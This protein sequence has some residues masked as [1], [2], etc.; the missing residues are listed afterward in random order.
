[1][2]RPFA[3]RSSPTV[4]A[5]LLLLTALAVIAPGCRSSGTT[6][7]QQP[8]RYVAA[9]RPSGNALARVTQSLDGLAWTVPQTIVDSSGSAVPASTSIGIAWD[10][11]LYHAAWFDGSRLRYATSGN[12]DDWLASASDLGTFP[13][14]S[15]ARPA[16]AAGAG[17]VLVAFLSGSQI[18]VVDI[19][20]PSPL[21]VSGSASAGPALAFGNGRF[22]LAFP[23]AAPRSLQVRTSGDGVTWATGANLPAAGFQPGAVALGFD[24]GRFQLVQRISVSTG[25]LSRTDLQTFTSSDGASWTAADV[26]RGQAFGTGTAIAG[27]AGGRLLLDAST[28]VH[29]YV[30]TSPPVAVGWTALNGLGLTRGRGRAMASFSLDSV[31]VT[32]AQERS[33]DEPYFLVYSFHSRVARPGSTRVH[34]SGALEKVGDDLGDGDMR[35]IPPAM[36]S[37]AWTIE[38]ARDLVDNTNG[39]VDIMGAVIVAIEEDG[40]PD[41][42]VAARAR[43]A[44]TVIAGAIESLIAGGTLG[45]LLNQ[46]SR[47]AAVAAATTSVRNSLGGGSGFKSFFGCATDRDDQIQDRIVLFVGTE[48]FTED[49][50]MRTFRI[51]PTRPTL[52]ISLTFTD[53]DTTWTVAATLRVH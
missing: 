8:V 27:S 36:G 51:D 18:V 43:Q 7:P 3:P 23:S 9:A 16:V 20:A 46:S 14:G 45:T 22:V 15:Q 25:T 28:R 29:A 21:V 6:A 44:E 2:R 4:P 48:L 42:G 47:N 49:P 33:G 35:P 50:S 24:G 52:P 41:S 17:K 1:M 38:P 26:P 31:T 5:A 32:R 39:Q 10:G 40:C 34:W 13:V 53:P 37:T 11:V 30:G 19:S 12:G